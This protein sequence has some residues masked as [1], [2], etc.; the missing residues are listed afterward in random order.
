[1]QLKK[2][3]YRTCREPG[4]AASIA[5]MSEYIQIL[6]G[7]QLDG[8]LNRCW[9]QALSKGFS[10]VS[11][12][13]DFLNLDPSAFVDS[14]FPLKV[15]MRYVEKIEKGN[16]NDPLL[17]QVIPSRKEEVK[18]SGFTSDP[19]SESQFLPAPGI[20]HKYK[21]RLLMVTTGACGIHC[22]YCFRRHFPYDDQSL[23][24]SISE[25]SFGY[26]QNSTQV[27]E[28]ILSGG[29]PLSL[30]DLKLK[31]ILNRL[32]EIPHLKRIRI[33]SR[34]LAILPERITENMVQ[35]F[36]QTP[37]KVIIVTHINH[38]NELDEFFALQLK[39]LKAAGVTLLNQSVLLKNI[40]DSDHVLVA[41]SEALFDAGIL[42]YYLHLLD[43]V[44]GA[45][46]FD[47]AEEK[48]K[49]IYAKIMANLPGFLVP[50]LVREEAGAQNKTLVL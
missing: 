24:P 46:H 14:H 47:V 25:Q 26:I 43:P 2:S 44:E 33:H 37:L 28:V 1:M 38:P 18:V 29:D 34:L 49:E 50:K 3:F 10:R 27:N 7:D 23:T 42:P 6:Q 21:N 48:A 40:N 12:L 30:S 32:E 35:L 41:L 8:H 15:P 13:C 5:P 39:W 9:K 31:S 45:A 36:S 20:I 11:D 4:F 22:R 17:L 16:P 19:L